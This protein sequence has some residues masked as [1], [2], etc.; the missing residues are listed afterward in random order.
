MWRNQG[1]KRRLEAPVAHPDA[2]TRRN[3]QALGRIIGGVEK[4]KLIENGN[5]QRTFVLLHL[6]R[7]LR[8]GGGSLRAFR[9]AM[10][11]GEWPRERQPHGNFKLLQCTCLRGATF[12][13]IEETLK[14]RRENDK[15]CKNRYQT[16]AVYLFSWRCSGPY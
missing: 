16:F 7:R 4:P 5:M 11:K 13:Q 15:S 8:W 14:S 1:L 2:L 10:L 9:R 12:S 3:A 6:T